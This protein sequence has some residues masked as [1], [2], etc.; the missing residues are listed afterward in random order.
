MIVDLVGKVPIGISLPFI[1]SVVT[2]SLWKT[3][4]VV[5]KTLPGSPSATEE[6]RKERTGVRKG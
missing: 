4:G 1:A 5:R 3:W 2:A 6:S